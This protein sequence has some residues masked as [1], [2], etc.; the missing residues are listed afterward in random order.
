MFPDRQQ[1]QQ[2]L[3]SCSGHKVQAENCHSSQS[4]GSA[5]NRLQAMKNR[6]QLDDCW[7]KAP[8]PWAGAR[9]ISHCLSHCLRYKCRCR[10]GSTTERSSL[11]LHQLRNASNLRWTRGP[12]KIQTLRFQ[13]KQVK[14][15][16]SKFI[17][18]TLFLSQ[19]VLF[20]QALDAQNWQHS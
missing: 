5:I 1:K 16:F 8:C 12:V 14:K 11:S 18:Y 13:R 3:Q 4:F 6:M 7:A 2:T 20:P 19:T 9:C 15:M 17:N 10:H